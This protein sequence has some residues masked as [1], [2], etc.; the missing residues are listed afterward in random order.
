LTNPEWDVLKACYLNMDHDLAV[1]GAYVSWETLNMLM[2]NHRIVAKKAGMANDTL[3]GAIAGLMSDLD[4]I[5]KSMSIKLG[6][7]ND[8]AKMHENFVNNF[9]ISFSDGADE[10]ARAAFLEAAQQ[11]RSIG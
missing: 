3:R 5:E 9:F 2:E 10:R 7:K 8:E 1:A 4:A 6:P 11:R